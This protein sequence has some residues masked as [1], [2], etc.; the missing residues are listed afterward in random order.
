MAK[1]KQGPALFE[2]MRNGEEDDA[3]AQR[4]DTR[5]AKL[6]EPSAPPMG[7]KSAPSAKPPGEGKPARRGV[8]PCFEPFCEVDSN[9]VRFSLT[10]K[11]ATIAAAVVVLVLGGACYLSY[12]FGKEQARRAIQERADGEIEQAR[13]AVPTSNLFDGIGEDPTTGAGVRDA[14]MAVAPAV[15]LGEGYD[16][17]DVPWV[18]GYN[19]I[20]VQDFRRDARGDAVQACTFLWENGIQTAIIE[21]EQSGAYG[22]RL[23]TAK[24]YNLEDQVQEQLAR[25]HLEKVRQLGK[26]YSQSG[27]QYDFQSAYFRKLKGDS[28]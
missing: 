25:E 14:A 21:L 15:V 9:R 5:S 4:V 23:I 18:S 22:Y 24:G 28:W 16:G 2:L 10:Q 26:V 13:Q 3:V 11:N 8:E 6:D 12:C 20:V 27:G 17:A 19:Y 7:Q 1:S